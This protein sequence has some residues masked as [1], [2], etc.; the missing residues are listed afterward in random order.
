MTRFTEDLRIRVTP[1]TKEAFVKLAALL[2]KK[3]S[4]LAREAFLAY[5]KKYQAEIDSSSE[6]LSHD[7]SL[8]DALRKDVGVRRG[9][10]RPH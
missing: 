4:E 2:E 8:A 7:K 5:L 3:E 1:E 9:S 10:R 6:S